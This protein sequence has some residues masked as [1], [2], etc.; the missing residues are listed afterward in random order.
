VPVSKSIFGGHIENKIEK[1]AV[2][3]KK[4]IVKIGHTSRMGNSSLLQF[5]RVFAQF[6]D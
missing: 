4:R 2:S 1:R 6:L 5:R 3:K